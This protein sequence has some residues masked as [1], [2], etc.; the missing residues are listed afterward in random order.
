M[1]FFE[2]YSEILSKSEDGMIETNGV[3]GDGYCSIWAILIGW[4]LLNRKNLIK[5]KIGNQKN[6]NPKTMDELINVLIIAGEAL[7]EDNFY[8]TSNL[9]YEHFNIEKWELENNEYGIFQ[10]KNKSITSIMGTSH[11]KLLALMLGIRIDILNKNNSKIE[12]F[13]DP[14]NDN[15]RISTNG[16]HYSIYNNRQTLDH[17]NNRYWWNLEWDGFLKNAGLDTNQMMMPYLKNL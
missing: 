9:V 5:N 10:L 1:E 8:V 6:M 16:A 7:L 11:I 17:F 2:K 15:I 12:S 4:S 3:R 14:Q 13:G